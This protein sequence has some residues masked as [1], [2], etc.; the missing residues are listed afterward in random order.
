M[1]RILDRCRD[2]E[3]R[4]SRAVYYLIRL[5]ITYN[6][7]GLSEHFITTVED[8]VQI[9]SQKFGSS[10]NGGYSGDICS[11]AGRE[12]GGAG[13]EGGISNPSGHEDRGTNE[14]RGRE[15]DM[16]MTKSSLRK[17]S[18]V[19]P[20]S[21][22]SE[23]GTAG[24]KSLGSKGKEPSQSRVWALKAKNLPSLLQRKVIH[25]S[26]FIYMYKYIHIY[27]Y[28]YIYVCIYL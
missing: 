25:I 17:N 20:Q 26:M 6:L 9:E 5:M 24:A 12:E 14:V 11:S 7:R 8:A 18:S 4:I 19:M 27:I 23:M 10:G 16:R 22:Q 2:S 1:M 21:T 28:I 15:K 3:N 13:E